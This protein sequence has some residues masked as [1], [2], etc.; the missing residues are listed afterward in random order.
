MNKSTKIWPNTHTGDLIKAAIL[1]KTLAKVTTNT[2]NSSTILKTTNIPAM[3][4]EM[5]KA[6]FL[7]LHTPSLVL[8]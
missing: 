3:L 6:L 4:M 2:K 5:E 7:I 1:S 8:L